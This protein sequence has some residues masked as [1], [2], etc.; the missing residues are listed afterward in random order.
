[1]NTLTI[2]LHML[3]VHHKN[4]LKRNDWNTFKEGRSCFCWSKLNILTKW[5]KL[6]QRK[7]AKYLSSYH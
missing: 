7:Q 2:V 1:V 4:V 5:T 3:N 6:A